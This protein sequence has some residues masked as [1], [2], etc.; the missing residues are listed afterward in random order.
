MTSSASHSL[1]IELP[2]EQVWDKLRDLSLAPH[3]VPNLTGCQLHRGPAHGQGASRRVLQKNGQWL[4]ETVEEWREGEGFLIRLHRGAK[5]APPPFRQAWFR[6]AIAPDGTRTRF[7]ASLIYRPAGGLFG[8][9]LDRLLLRRAL[10]KVVAQIA[11]NLKVFYETG[12]TQN[13]AFKPRDI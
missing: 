1:H 13:P 9:L 5:G 10:N 8:R 4:D 12:E 6:Y 7:T 3:Y 11:V 2:Q